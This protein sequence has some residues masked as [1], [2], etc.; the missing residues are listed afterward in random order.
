MD[1]GAI[2]T[3]RSLCPIRKRKGALNYIFTSSRKMEA[4]G[5]AGGA[6]PCIVGIRVAADLHFLTQGA[7]KTQ[8]PMAQQPGPPAAMPP[9][10]PYL[11]LKFCSRYSMLTRKVGPGSA[12]CTDT[13]FSNWPSRGYRGE[14]GQLGWGWP[15]EQS[16]WW[17]TEPASAWT[18]SMPGVGKGGVGPRPHPV[19]GR[20]FYSSSPGRL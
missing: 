17:S 14:P 10:D 13:G 8:R 2:G 5:T 9:P 6:T 3:D 7:S 19:L 1:T 12:C 15:R 11:R 4:G 16:H 20:T 18:P